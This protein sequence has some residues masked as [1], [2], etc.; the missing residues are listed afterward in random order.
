MRRLLVVIFATC[1]LPSIVHATPEGKARGASTPKTGKTFRDCAGCPDMIIIPAGSFAMGS[2]DSEKGRDKDEGPVHQVS[3]SSFALSKTEITRG[4]FAAF[5]SK[6]HY[7]AGDTCWTLQDGKYDSRAGNWQNPGYPQGDKH[8]VTCINWEDAQAYAQWMSQKTGKKYRL[9]SEAE[10]EYAAR[11][12]TQ[13]IRYWGANP[14]QACRYANVAD[15][16]AQTEIKGTSAWL[17]HNC[18]DGFAYTA[19]VGHF[20]A[21][22]FGLKDM[23]GNV[24]EWTEDSYHENYKDAPTEGSAWQGDGVKR[25][26]RGGSWNNEPQNVR[27][28]IRNGN[29]ATQRFSIFGFRLAREIK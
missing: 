1:C 28:A 23:L 25:V 19:P 4:Q 9:P 6:A 22:A 13:S 7:V 8:P 26:L 10:W 17:V 18:M 27:S 20:K 16:T 14:D 11:G 5:A 12:Q 15:K 3:I 21:N 29:K 24:W 2:P